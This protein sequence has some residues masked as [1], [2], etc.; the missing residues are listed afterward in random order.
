MRVEDRPRCLS[1]DPSI[2]IK[3]MNRSI[4]MKIRPCPGCHHPTLIPNGAYW[5]CDRCFYAITTAALG[6]EQPR[7]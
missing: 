5:F 3:S 6:L 4:V 2:P 1:V 7:Q